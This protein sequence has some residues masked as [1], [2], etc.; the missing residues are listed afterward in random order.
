MKQVYYY[1]PMKYA[2]SVIITVSAK[3]ASRCGQ[4]NS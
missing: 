3:L 2:L 1:Y 4:K